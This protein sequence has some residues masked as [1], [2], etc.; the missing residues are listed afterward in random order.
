MGRIAWVLVGLMI[1][2]GLGYIVITSKPNDSVPQTDF[3]SV[4]SDLTAGASL[5]DVRT[6]E[7]YEDGH[8][9]GAT[10]FPLQDI[11]SGRLPDVAKDTTIYV[12]CRSGNRSSQA[13]QLLKKAGYTNIVDLGGLSDVQKIGGDLSI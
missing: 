1:L 7:E 3:A 5:L 6:K 2:A 8:F 9:E 12:Y 10:L 4:Q 13:S 11:E